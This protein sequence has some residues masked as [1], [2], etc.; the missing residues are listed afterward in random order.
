MIRGLV[1][2][3][4]SW[5]WSL[6][7][8]QIIL[9]LDKV[10]IFFFKFEKGAAQIPT[11]SRIKW[12]PLSNNRGAVIPFEFQANYSQADLDIIFSAFKMVFF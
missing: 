10:K 5:S 1:W 8:T 4:H 9:K 7:L 3:W 6:K 12:D 2:G 11:S